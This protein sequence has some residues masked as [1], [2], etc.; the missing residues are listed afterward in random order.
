MPAVHLCRTLFGC[1]ELR[2]PDQ[3]GVAEDPDVAA[4]T[5]GVEGALEEVGGIAR[6]ARE[7]VSRCHRQLESVA[8]R[9]DESMNERQPPRTRNPSRT[10]AKVGVAVL[11]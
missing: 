5:P 7:G 2:T 10:L 1:L 11:L 6:A 8:P 3:R 9:L 4:L